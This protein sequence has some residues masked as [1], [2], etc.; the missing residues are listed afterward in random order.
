MAS[1]SVSVGIDP[2]ASPRHPR[3]AEKPLQCRALSAKLPISLLVG[4]MSDRTEGGAKDRYRALLFW[5]A[6]FFGGCHGPIGSQQ[7][8]I[9]STR[10]AERID[11]QG[12]SRRRLA[13]AGIVEVVSRPGR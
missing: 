9:A 2:F 11:E 13:T 3:P 8:C 4:E 12:E 1:F 6:A 7:D 5:A 10:E